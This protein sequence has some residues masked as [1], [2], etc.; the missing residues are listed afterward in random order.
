MILM[1]INMILLFIL[2][3]LS[4]CAQYK[5]VYPD[6]CDIQQPDKD[7]QDERNSQAKHNFEHV[8]SNVK[9]GL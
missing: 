6:T 7:G 8:F 3:L 1:Q 4:G 2:L 5:S 9:A